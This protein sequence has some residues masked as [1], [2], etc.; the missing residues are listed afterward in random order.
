LKFRKWV[1][2]IRKIATIHG[3][4]IFLSSVEN[5]VE[6]I[7][8]QTQRSTRKSMK[9]LIKNIFYDFQ[10]TLFYFLNLFPIANRSAFT[11]KDVANNENSVYY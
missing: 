7:S 5:R 11:K 4:A 6:L 8:L 10:H 9:K 1:F 3:Y 2:V